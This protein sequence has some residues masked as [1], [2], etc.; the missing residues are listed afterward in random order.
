MNWTL[1]LVFLT[2]SG[3]ATAVLPNTYPSESAC[4]DAGNSTDKF[5]SIARTVKVLCVPSSK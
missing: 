2:T 1:V 5:D 3:P 4:Y